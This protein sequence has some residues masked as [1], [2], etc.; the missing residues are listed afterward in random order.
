MNPVV[1][2]VVAVYNAEDCLSRC[3]DSLISQSFKDIEIICVND[4]S[5]DKS[6]QIIEQYAAKDNRVRY[7]VHKE[8]KNA[9]GAMNDGIKAARGEYVCIVDNDDWLDSSCIEILLGASENRTIDIVSCDWYKYFSENK[10]I[11]NKNLSDSYDKTDN[12]LYSLKNGWRILGSLIRTSIFKSNDLYYPEKVFFEDNAIVTCILCYANSIKP[13]HKP[14][15]YYFETPSSVT[16]SVSQK[17]VTDRIFTTDLFLKNLEERGFAKQYDLDLIYYRYLLFSNNTL[18]ML[19]GSNESWADIVIDELSGKI[20]KRMPNK[21]LEE[22]RPHLVK[23]LSN[24]K[25]FYQK[26]KFINRIKR[27]IPKGIRKILS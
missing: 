20:L 23:R 22:L 19:I 8:N 7:I 27:I 12:I 6:Q 13:V 14:L 17:K 11:E 16:R 1:S 2:I 26:Q 15:Y 10:K 25:R 3:L 4:A 24:P 18:T 5:S 21:T 9:G